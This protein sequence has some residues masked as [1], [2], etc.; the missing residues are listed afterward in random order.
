MKMTNRNDDTTI[1]MPEVEVTAPV[2]VTAV[3][4]KRVRKA[5]TAPENATKT[6]LRELAASSDVPVTKVAPK[7]KKVV[8]KAATEKKAVKKAPAKKA[9]KKVAKK[10]D[11]APRELSDTQKAI[12]RVMSRSNGATIHDLNEAG[13]N[14][15]A[16]QAVKMAE[17]HGM[18]VSQ[19]KADGELTHYFA[20]RVGG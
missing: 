20:K 6:E 18:K 19:K 17:R 3:P 1:T 7:G 8:K 13:H 9:A 4:K 5:A 11:K 15:A 10:T 14:A 16:S 2:E 12:F